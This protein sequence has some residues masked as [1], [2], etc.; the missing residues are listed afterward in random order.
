MSGID[1]VFA[2]GT[3]QLD[4][5]MEAVTGQRFEA[6]R[7]TLPGYRRNR[8]VDRSYPGVTPAPDAV[9]LGCLYR[10]IDA[11]TLER[12]D[13]FESEIYDRLE[14]TVQ[15]GASQADPTARAWVYVVAPRYRHL[16]SPDPWDLDAFMRDHG[17]VFIESCKRFRVEGVV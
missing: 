11:P 2:Y 8:L 14:L 5:V 15:M 16:L 4:E 17:R 12:L 10:G 7:A 1:A 3:L 13:I 9:T 6:A